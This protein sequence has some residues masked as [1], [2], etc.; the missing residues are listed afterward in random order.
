MK[1][2]FKVLLGGF[3]L[4]STLVVLG[5]AGGAYWSWQK[6][7]ETGPHDKNVQITISK[8]SSIGGIADQ[9]SYHSAID[10]PLVF[11][12]AGRFTGQADKLK[13]GEYEIPAKASMREILDLLES[14]KVVL[15]QIT[16]REGLTNWEIKK[17]LLAHEE[18]EPV[19]GLAKILPEGSYLPETYSYQKGD[20][21]F[22]IMKQ[23]NSAMENTV[24]PLCGILLERIANAS[25]SDFLPEDC[26]NAK[27]PLK[28]V[29]DVLTLASIIEK[30]T[31]VPDE[32]RR[33]AGVFFN[34]LKIGMA[35]QTDPTVI[36]ALTLGKH[37]NGGQG[38][39]G[40]RL[41]KKDLAFDSP[42]NTY[43]Y[44]GLPP[45]P[46]ANPG[47]ASIEAALNP[48]EH[49]YIYFVADGTGG[50]AF[51]KTLNEHNNNAAKWRK[52]RREQD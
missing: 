17:L 23:M 6:F 21:A 14:G 40:R 44:A 34:R 48:E 10:H 36:Y 33:V 13:A 18:L 35:L 1:F 9:L 32:R 26:P 16:I 28:T 7:I 8:G 47:K 37:E 49:K 51:S 11:K 19:E 4:V 12:I 22:D 5:I 20:T 38:P 50:H 15:R 3:V 30:E 2:F 25:F 41:L 31:A 43:K 24:L 42:Y 52:I 45:G 39:L 46:I 27:A 29:N